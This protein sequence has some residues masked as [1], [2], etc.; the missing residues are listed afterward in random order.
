MLPH[1]QGRNNAVA[2]RRPNGRT[3][4][5][6]QKMSKNL[7]VPYINHC[8]RPCHPGHRALLNLRGFRS[9]RKA[10]SS[11]PGALGSHLLRQPAEMPPAC[12]A[13]AASHRRAVAGSSTEPT[14]APVEVPRRGWSA[15]SKFLL[16]A[17]QRR[18]KAT[19]Y[20]RSAFVRVIVPMELSSA[21]GS[22]QLPK[23]IRARSPFQADLRVPSKRCTTAGDC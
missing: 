6:E 9:I 5:G 3:A 14:A 13:P 7:R 22:R 4:A 23:A 17:E 19:S 1:H 11:Q 10:A 21:S 2:Y 18:F 8:Y 12:S 15:S 16:I 20:Q